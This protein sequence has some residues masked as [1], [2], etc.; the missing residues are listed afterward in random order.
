[1]I[2][3]PKEK[4]GNLQTLKVIN[5]ASVIAG[6]FICQLFAEQGADVIQIESSRMRDMY[7]IWPEAWS[8][9]RRN[10]RCMTLNIPTPQGK[11]VLFKLLADAD[12]LVESSRGGTWD[13]WGLTDEV[14]WEVKPDLVIVHVSGFGQ[15]GDPDYLRRAS[16][17]SIGQAFSGYMSINGFPDPLPPYVTKPYTGDFIAGL[18]GA[19]ATLAA[20]LRARETGKGESIDV[21]QFEAV[22]RLQSSY[23]TDGIN[24]GKQ[25]PRMG[26]EDTVGA[27]K[28]TQRCKDGWI[29]I[30]VGGA[31]PIR[32]MIEL[33]GLGNDPD[34]EGTIQTV[35]RH[36]PERARKFVEKLDAYCLERTVAEVEAELGPL[37]VA[38]S[39]IM[40]Y[41]MMVDNSH[42]QQ[43]GVFE[44]WTD[45]A[46]GETVKGAAPVPRFKNN[47]SQTVRSGVPYDYDTREVMAEHGYTD[48]QIDELYAD[49]ILSSGTK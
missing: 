26:N 34:F 35:T 42:Y 23:L 4:F 6:P 45:V 24:K 21:A 11:E 25:S 5:A 10:Q 14:L 46:T 44:E 20:V 49:G 47:P 38:L 17:D 3:L 9:D 39:P 12:V 13:N 16:Y 8:M 2:P 1:M 18:T 40:T 43:R 22:V 32:N 48:E 37:G 36:F 41:Q 31:K 29:F 33:F 28:G 7:R 27:C 19:W 15:T 30:A